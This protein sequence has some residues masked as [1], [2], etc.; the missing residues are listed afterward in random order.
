MD[1]AHSLLVPAICTWEVALLANRGRL[2]L[3]APIKEWI[4]QALAEDRIELAPLEWRIAMDAADLRDQGFHGDPV[5]G[6]VYAT[7]RHA[8]AP[9]ITVDALITAFDSRV[10]ARQRTLVV[11]D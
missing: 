11:W 9:L 3:N 5:D 10:N 1:R 8:H 2:T 7:A 6:L 4:P